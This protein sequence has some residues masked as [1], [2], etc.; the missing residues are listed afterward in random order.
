MAAVGLSTIGFDYRGSLKMDC[1]LIQIG[2]CFDHYLICLGH[3]PDDWMF[4]SVKQQKS[5]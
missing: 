3:G 2:V 1:S 5:W 4:R